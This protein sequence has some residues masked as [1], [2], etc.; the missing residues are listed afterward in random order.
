VKCTKEHFR[1]KQHRMRVL[2]QR[3]VFI[4]DENCKIF[5]TEVIEIKVMRQK[6]PSSRSS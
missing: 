2:L 4:T 3:T 1:V 5:F 6:D